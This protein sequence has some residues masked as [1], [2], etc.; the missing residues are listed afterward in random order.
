MFAKSIASNNDEAAEMF[1]NDVNH[2]KVK[3]RGAE[4]L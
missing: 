4:S 1:I 2:N 3:L